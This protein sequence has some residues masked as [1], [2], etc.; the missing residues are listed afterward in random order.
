MNELTKEINTFVSDHPADV[1]VLQ[2]SF[3]KHVHY[4]DTP[5]PSALYLFGHRVELCVRY[6]LGW[7]N[8]HLPL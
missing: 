7:F 8:E 6:E 3:F 1:K 2:V 5:L 4:I